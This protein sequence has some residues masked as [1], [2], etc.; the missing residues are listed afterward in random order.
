MY[1]TSPANKRVTHCHIVTQKYRAL[2]NLSHG[3]P[4]DGPSVAFP[5]DSVMPAKSV[6]ISA[7]ALPLKLCCVLEKCTQFQSLLQDC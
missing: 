6:N 5:Q 4:K 3:T 7:E 1:T 2:F